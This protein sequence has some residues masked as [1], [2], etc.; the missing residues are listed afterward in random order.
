MAFG[1][2]LLAFGNIDVVLRSEAK[3]KALSIKNN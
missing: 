1:Y 2:W 3:H